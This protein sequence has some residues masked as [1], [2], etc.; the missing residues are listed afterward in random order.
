LRLASDY[1]HHKKKKNKKNDTESDMESIVYSR[2]RE[3]TKPLSILKKLI[4]GIGELP[5]GLLSGVTGTFFNV[6]LRANY[7]RFRFIDWTSAWA[8]VLSRRIDGPNSRRIF[9]SASV[10]P[11]KTTWPYVRLCDSVWI[12][13]LLFNGATPGVLTTE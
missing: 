10:S 11:W 7:R 13:D 9:R 5:F 4:Y 1:Q 12:I 3:R 6:V 8:C 2:E